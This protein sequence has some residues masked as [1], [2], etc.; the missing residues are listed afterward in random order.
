MIMGKETDYLSL[1]DSSD[2]GTPD[3]KTYIMVRRKSDVPS[4]D[5]MGC[6]GGACLG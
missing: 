4:F 2:I 5:A 6:P 3:V 1:T